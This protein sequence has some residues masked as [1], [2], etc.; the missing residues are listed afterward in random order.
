MDA[1]AVGLYAAIKY[2]DFDIFK[3]LLAAGGK[4]KQ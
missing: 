4:L 3:M 1:L 2:G